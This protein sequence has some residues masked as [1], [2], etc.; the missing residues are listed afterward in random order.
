MSGA[1]ASAASSTDARCFETDASTPPWLSHGLT[2][3]RHRWPA[4]RIH[5]EPLLADLARRGWLETSRPPERAADLILAWS[6]GRGEPTAL[7]CFVQQQRPILRATLGSDDGVQH[8]LVH[9]L[10]ATPDRAARIA[11]FAGQSS[12]RSWV[13]VVCRRLGQQQQRRVVLST[14]SIADTVLGVEADP[15]LD[16]LKAHYAEH[17]EHALQA[18]VATL[19]A[20]DRALLRALLAGERSSSIAARHGVHK[21]TAKRW[22]ADLRRRLL[23]RTRR[24]LLDRLQVR[25]EELDSILRLIASRIPQAR[26][27]GG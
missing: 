4:L 18:A 22:L 8:G 23:V 17:F 19:G 26:P 16:V 25:A 11:S 6:C 1:Q 14:D 21:A 7:A 27:D 20:R 12:L 5:T 2:L 10:V 15:E 13:R 24:W 9:I 3:A